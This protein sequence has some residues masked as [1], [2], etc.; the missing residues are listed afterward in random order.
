MDEKILNFWAQHSERFLE[1]A[2]S[3]NKREVLHQPDGYGTLTREC[4]DT[5]EIYLGLRNGRIHHASFQTN[6][7]LY[8]VVCANSAVH[9]VSGKTLQE[10]WAITPQ[11]IM[12]YLETLPPKRNTVLNLPFEHSR[13]LSKI[14]TTRRSSHGRSS[15]RVS[16]T[17]IQGVRRPLPPDKRGCPGES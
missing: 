16:E 12:D 3:N 1:M 6:G 14:F 9:L 2:L 10:A 13:R 5:V 4:G 17:C 15:T 7:C 8:A 11:H